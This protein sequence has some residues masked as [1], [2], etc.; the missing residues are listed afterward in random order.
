MCPNSVWFV[1]L[2]LTIAQADQLEEKTSL[3]SKDS[4]SENNNTMSGG[5]LDFPVG[6]NDTEDENLNM[7]TICSDFS[8]GGDFTTICQFWLQGVILFVVGLFGICGNSV[9][10]SLNIQN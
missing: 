10:R 3:S 8:G 7:T 4:L 9:S 2:L 6:E 5:I 1:L